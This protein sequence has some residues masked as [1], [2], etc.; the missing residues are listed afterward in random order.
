MP[1]SSGGKGSGFINRRQGEGREDPAE[2]YEGGG[3]SHRPR[4]L[5]FG[6]GF[7]LPSERGK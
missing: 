6:G 3:P 1:N 4:S 5:V 7:V 2:K